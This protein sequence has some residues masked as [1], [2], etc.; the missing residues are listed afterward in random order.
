M[1]SQ[2][3]KVRANLCTWSF[4]CFPKTKKK[5]KIKIF[6][7]KLLT[8][9]IFNL[10]YVL[11]SKFPSTKII[12]PVLYILPDGTS[13]HNS[14]SMCSGNCRLERRRSDTKAE[15]TKWKELRQAR[16]WYQN[17]RPS[18]IRNVTTAAI[19]PVT[20]TGYCLIALCFIPV[21]LND[22]KAR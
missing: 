15:P 19:T 14:L 13:E 9:P 4:S 1:G 11:Q 10:K 7:F 3:S 5:F 21:K 16:R 12:T 18:N 2:N 8:E 17:P 6:V 22:C 20:Y